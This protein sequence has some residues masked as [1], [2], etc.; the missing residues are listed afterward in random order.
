MAISSSLRRN[1]A[2]VIRRN[3]AN[4]YFGEDPTGIA[5]NIACLNGEYV[6]GLNAAG[7]GTVNLIGVNAANQV[8]TG[9]G[10]VLPTAE[11]FTANFDAATCVSRSI[12]IAATTL[13]VANVNVVFGTASASGTV[14]VEHLTGTQ[15][16]GGGTVMLTGTLSTAGTANTVLAGTLVATVATLQLAAGDRIGLVVAGTQTGLV[17][18][19]IAITLT[20]F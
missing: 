16:P 6:L 13:Q 1:W 18:F 7:T 10:T 9:S 3:W 5:Q 20:R 19:D 2:E 14:T 4:A 15:A 17:G 8:V 12:Y 11:H